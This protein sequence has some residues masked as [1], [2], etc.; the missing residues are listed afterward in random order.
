MSYEKTIIIETNCCDGVPEIP[1]LAIMRLSTEKLKRVQR[2]FSLPLL[3]F[4][5]W[6]YDSDYEIQSVEVTSGKSGELIFSL[7]DNEIQTQT[8]GVPEEALHAIRTSSVTHTHHTIGTNNL[9]H[10]QV[11]KLFGP[12]NIHF[13]NGVVETPFAQKRVIASERIFN[14]YVYVEND[15]IRGLGATV[16]EANGSPEEKLSLLQRTNKDDLVNAR[17]FPV[18]SRYLL[19]AAGRTTQIGQLT[20]DQFNRLA[21]A[22]Q[23]L[24]IFAEVLSTVGAPVPPL[25]CVSPVVNGALP[26]MATVVRTK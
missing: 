11:V 3:P 6:P 19:N 4:Q 24:D 17:R 15:V 20:H 13:H 23:I 25:Y 26:V 8:I 22:G 18:P 21:A 7:A 9:F 10:E 12:L 5:W 1:A 16:R 14:L 2:V